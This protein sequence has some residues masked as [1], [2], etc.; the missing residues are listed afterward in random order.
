MS[1]ETEEPIEAS[2]EESARVEKLNEP[3]I[4]ELKEQ[5]EKEKNNVESCEEK[6]KRLLADF[7]NL[8]KRTSIDIE[9]NVNSQVD[10]LMLKFLNIYDDF[11]RG[12]DVLAKQKIN[13]EGLEA[14]IKNMNILFLEHQVTPVDALGEIFDPTMHEAI[15]VKE[16]PLLDDGTIT[17]EIRKGYKLS[18]R[19]LRPS[20]VEISKKP[21]TSKEV[22]EKNG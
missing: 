22:D 12:K 9:T 18:D 13:V 21:N 10:E 5:L 1:K 16:D 4:D 19:I 15:S 17:N 11:I 7:D 20:L 6:L 2:E 14:I 3:T 8:K